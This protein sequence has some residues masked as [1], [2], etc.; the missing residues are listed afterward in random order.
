MYNFFLSEKTRNNRMNNK[1]II[2]NIPFGVILHNSDGVIVEANK[3]VEQ[4]LKIS[5]NKI[6]GNKWSELPFKVINKEGVECI[7]EDAIVTE[8]LTSGKDVKD[9]VVGIIHSGNREIIWIN[10][11]ILF[12]TFKVGNNPYQNQALMYLSDISSII[13]T[14]VAV[15]N[16]I[17]NLDLGSWQWDIDLGTL[18]FNDKWAKML[19]YTIDELSPYSIDIWHKLIHP[20]DFKTMEDSLLAHFDGKSPQYYC[21]IRLLHKSGQWVWVRHIGKVT[22]RSNK[23]APLYMT[24]IHQDISDYKKNELELSRKIEYGKILSDISSKFIGTNDIDATIIES[25]SKLASLNQASRVYLF[26]INKENGTISNTHEWCN[27]G[28]LSQKYMLQNLPMS[29]FPWWVEK[30]SHEEFI[31]ISDVSAME[32]D[33]KEILEKQGIKSL[34]IIPVTIKQSFVGFIGFDN[35]IASDRWSKD[36]IDL[37][38]TTSSVFSYALDRQISYNELSKSYLNLR[39]YFD[40]N[41]DFVMILNEQGEIIEV[42]N[43]VKERL[44]YSDEDIIGKHVLMMHPSHV[45]EEA[46]QIVQSMI[47]NKTRSCPLPILTKNGKQILVETSVTKGVWDGKP[48]LFGISKDIS[49]KVFSEEKFEKIFQNIPTIATLTDL[50]TGKYTEVNRAFYEKLGFTINEAIGSNAQ[51]SNTYL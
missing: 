19:G 47:D 48:A 7:I 42:N 46:A 40:L 38:S 3:Q 8:V 21:E 32:T 18:I 33:E 1:L 31:H 17:N 51:T 34:L 43:V 41:S 50:T 11:T 5:L 39:A 30:F 14:N 49:E 22:L 27:E 25:F 4:I 24:G 13:S 28:V 35:V 37:L 2:E 26:M 10:A 23:G 12:K 9:Q 16:T 36:D 29:E 6:I 20:D 45:R 15:E 44:G